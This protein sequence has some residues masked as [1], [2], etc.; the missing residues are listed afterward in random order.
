[1]NEPQTN[2]KMCFNT[3]THGR[4][5]HAEKLPIDSSQCICALDNPKIKDAVNGTTGDLEEPEK[6]YHSKYG[7]FKG[8]VQPLKQSFCPKCLD[9]QMAT[10]YDLIDAGG[11][12]SVLSMAINP[13]EP[14]IYPVKARTKELNSS[15]EQAERK[16]G[17]AVVEKDY[18]VPKWDRDW[19][20][21]TRSEMRREIREGKMEMVDQIRVLRGI[22][23]ANGITTEEIE[24]KVQAHTGKRREDEQNAKDRAEE[25]RQARIAH[26]EK[27]MSDV[28][29]EKAKKK[30]AVQVKHLEHMN[31]MQKEK[32]RKEAAI[33]EEHLQRMKDREASIL[34]SV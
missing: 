9:G 17:L 11:L 3:Q 5:G 34:F 23:K 25:K 32:K 28:A 12:G 10:A 7:S 33:E 21:K 30:A 13:G 4:C 18:P 6:K 29:V 22:V 14:P 2:P 20:A 31:E 19:E 8:E 1:M 16:E 24:Q 15:E 27:E 26:H